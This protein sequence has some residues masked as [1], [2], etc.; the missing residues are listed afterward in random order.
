MFMPPCGFAYNVQPMCKNCKMPNAYDCEAFVICDLKKWLMVEFGFRVE[1]HGSHYHLGPQLPHQECRC[2]CHHHHH[3][4]R[5]VFF[6]LFMKCL[7]HARLWW[8][9][10]SNVLSQFVWGVVV[11]QYPKCHHWCVVVDNYVHLQ[12]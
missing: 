3:H 8:Y 7:S 5:C 1:I 2:H 9:F 10:G 11:F 6:F 12:K 4:H